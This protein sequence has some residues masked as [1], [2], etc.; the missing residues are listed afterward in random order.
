ME[1]SDKHHH[2]SETNLQFKIRFHTDKEIIKAE[3]L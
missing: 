1:T 3:K 2:T